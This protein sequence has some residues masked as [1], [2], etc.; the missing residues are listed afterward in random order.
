MTLRYMHV[1]VDGHG[2]NG[3]REILFFTTH[4]KTKARNC[5]GVK[6]VTFPPLVTLDPNEQ[7]I[8]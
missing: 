2:D 8:K 7:P 5:K 6:R 1:I 4:N 3:P